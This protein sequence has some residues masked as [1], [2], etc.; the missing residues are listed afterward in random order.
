MGVAAETATAATRQFLSE[1]IYSYVVNTLISFLSIKS[2]TRITSV[3]GWFFFNNLFDLCR[4]G[5]SHANEFQLCYHCVKNYFLLLILILSPVNDILGNPAFKSWK[6]GKN[7]SIFVL[8]ML[9]LVP[10]YT[11]NSFF[12]PN[13][14]YPELIPF[15]SF[16][17][18]LL[19]FVHM[20]LHYHNIPPHF[21]RLFFFLRA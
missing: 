2:S 11:V 18:P 12:I 19:I 6:T 3:F 8:S 20:Y 21:H 7:H 5:L 9:L 16:V 13:L 4:S 17:E 10:H 14:K 1:K 15:S